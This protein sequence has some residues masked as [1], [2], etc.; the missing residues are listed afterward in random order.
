MKQIKQWMKN[1]KNAF[2]FSIVWGLGVW[3]KLKSALC[4][5][6]KITWSTDILWCFIKYHYMK[7]I[8]NNLRL[9]SLRNI[10]KL[11]ILRI[12][13]VTNEPFAILIKALVE[14]RHKKTT[15]KLRWQPGILLEYLT[16]RPIFKLSELVFALRTHQSK[17]ARILRTRLLLKMMPAFKSQ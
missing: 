17:L 9:F 5:D 16:H 15:W 7:Y 2:F 14:F 11:L 8:L 10:F 13:N 4:A 6:R 3:D 1:K 12:S